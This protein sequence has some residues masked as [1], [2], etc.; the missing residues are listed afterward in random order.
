MVYVTYVLIQKCAESKIKNAYEK[1]LRGQPSIPKRAFV[2]L[3]ILQS[4]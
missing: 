3:V 1:R 4:R 2:Y